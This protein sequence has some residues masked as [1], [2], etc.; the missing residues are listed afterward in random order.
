MVNS[1]NDIRKF[2]TTINSLTPQKPKSSFPN[3]INTPNG[4]INITNAIAKEFN[5]HFCSIGKKLSDEVDTS[6][7]PRFNSI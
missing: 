2:W 1:I 3:S 5:N 6:N 7:S 4:L